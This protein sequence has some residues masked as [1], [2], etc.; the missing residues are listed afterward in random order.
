MQGVIPL[1]VNLLNQCPV[2][3]CFIYSYIHHIY[4]LLI[5]S[6]FIHTDM[7]YVLWCMVG[8]IWYKFLNKRFYIRSVFLFLLPAAAVVVV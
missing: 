5:L 8:G 1:R 2:Y 6:R 3:A 7:L 4:I